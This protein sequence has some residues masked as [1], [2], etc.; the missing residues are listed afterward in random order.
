LKELRTFSEVFE[1]IKSDYVEPV[2]DA[3]LLRNAIHGMLSALDPHSAYLVPDDYRELRAGTSGE[4]GGLGIEVGMENGFIR[5]I[6]PIDGTPAA[7]R[8][9]VKAGDLIVKLDDTPVKGLTL[10]QAIKRMRGKPGTAIVLTVMREGSEQPLKISIT[11]A[12]IKITSVRSRTLEPGYGYV[13]ISQFQARTSEN[14]IEQLSDLKETGGGH[15]E[16]LVLD[17]R[18]NP[19]GVLPGAV[20]VADAFLTDGL[21]VYTRGR[22]DSS[23][24]RYTAKPSDILDGAPMVVLVNSGSASASEIVAGAL[25]DHRR[26][27]IM[28]ERTFG[29]GSVQTI[30]PMVDGSALKLTTARYYTPSGRSIQAKGIEPDV[31]IANLRIERVA[32]PARIKETDLAHHLSAA[33]GGGES[34]GSKPVNA[35]DTLAKT[36]YPLYEALNLL[37]GLTI[38]KASDQR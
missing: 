12:I 20:Q 29:K 31:K 26:A 15:L 11:R 25:Q 36:D 23:K 2:D 22:L 8:G 4:F 38:L 37:K 21:I 30:L 24:T 34:D 5:V 9:G 14:M 6:S 33:D 28:G 35:P 16:G 10:N 7:R 1:K 17:L 32:G 13:R 27:V 18:N 3:S 19:G